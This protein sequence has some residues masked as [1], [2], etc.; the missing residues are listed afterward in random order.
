[1][2]PEDFWYFLIWYHVAVQNK[3]GSKP[4]D[5]SLRWCLLE[6]MWELSCVPACHD[7]DVLA[8]CNMTFCVYKTIDMQGTLQTM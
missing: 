8:F 4:Q 3:A 1:M 6:V 2:C 7:V 5:Q